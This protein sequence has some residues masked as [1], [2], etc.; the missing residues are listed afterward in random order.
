MQATER[1]TIYTAFEAAQKA[2]GWDDVKVD[3]LLEAF[4]EA[5]ANVQGL[6]NPEKTR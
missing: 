3:R 4:P 5:L 2:L 6:R 1:R